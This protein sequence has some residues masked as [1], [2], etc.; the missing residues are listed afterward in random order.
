MCIRD[1]DEVVDGTLGFKATVTNLTLV[2]VKDLGT[3]QTPTGTTDD[4][5]YL[6][7]AIDD[8][9]GDLIGLES[10]L[11]FHAYG[12]DALIN[13]AADSDANPATTAA[14][15]DWSTAGVHAAGYTGLN[16]DTELA[17]LGNTSLGALTDSIDISLKGGVALNALGGVLVAK[18]DFTLKLG[19]V[20]G[21]SANDNANVMTLSL[22]GV[23][24]WVGLG[25]SLSDTTAGVDL[26]L[27][28]I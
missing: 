11:E 8:F 23:E 15:L 18:T 16:I 12:V 1:S 9:A 20:S 19:Q 26:S 22:S 21:L 24:V 25:G 27:I 10:I 13:Q 4:T 2:S 7:L 17:A 28:H 14:K 6:A 3:D 5:S